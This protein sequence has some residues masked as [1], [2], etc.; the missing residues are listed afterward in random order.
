MSPVAYV[1]GMQT[2][3]KTLIT[4]LGVLIL[5][6][7][8]IGLTMNYFFFNINKLPIGEFLTEETS[9][10]G[11]YTI[12]AYVSGGGAT[13]ADAVRAELIFNNSNDKTENIYWN[14]RE[15]KA[16]IE[17][18]ADDIVV[19]NG[20]TLRVPKEKFDFRKQ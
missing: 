3:K 18:I 5:F 14:Y 1:K 16:E 7:F 8:L 4:L 13:T 20:K 2:W 17:W 15:E 9:L 19:I 11:T 10:E 12:K 6:F